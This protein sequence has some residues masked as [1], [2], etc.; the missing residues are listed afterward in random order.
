MRPDALRHLRA[1]ALVVLLAAVISALFLAQVPLE[2]TRAFSFGRIDGRTASNFAGPETAP[3]GESYRWTFGAGELVLASQAPGAHILDIKLSAPRPEPASIPVQV[4][5]NG[6]PLLDVALD[7]TAREYRVVVPAEMLHIGTNHIVLLSPTFQPSAADPR[8]LGIVAFDLSWSAVAPMPWLVPLQ[9]VSVVLVCAAACWLLRAGGAGVAWR[10]VAVVL[11]VAIALAMRHGDTRFIYRWNAIWVCLL[12]A[13]TLAALAFAV[14]RWPNDQP[15]RQPFLV[16]MRQ[17]APAAGLFVVLTLLTFAPLLLNITTSFPGEV[18]DANEYLWKIQWFTD[19]LIHQ[20]RS[21]AFVPHIFYPSGFELALSE[22]TPVT[23]LLG[24]PLTL[25]FGG[26][27]TYNL[28][29]VVSFVLTGFFTYLLAHRLGANR[30]AALVAGVLFGFCFRHFFH[31]T[32]H[33]PLIPMQWMVLAWYGWEGVLVRRR[34]WDGLVAGFGL[35]LTFWA[36]WYYGST[37]VLLLALYTLIRSGRQLPMLWRSWRPAL[38]AGGIVLLLVAPI[39]QPYLELRAAELMDKHSY[40]QM[41]IHAAQPADYLRTNPL[42]PLWGSWAASFYRPV[43]GEYFV[44]VGVVAMVLGTIGVLV[45]RR[46]PLVWALALIAAINVVL[47]FGPELRIGETVYSMPVRFIY[48]HVP[49]LDGI[50]VWSRM[51]IYV[52]LCAALL[53]SV[54]LSSVPV[55][56]R[57]AGWAVGLALAVSETATGITLA[58]AAPRPVDVWLGQQPNDGAVIEMPNGFTGMSEYATLFSKRPTAI[59]YGTFDPRLYLESRSKLATFP[60]EQALD[61]IRRWGVRY[62]VVNVAQ[63]ERTRPDWID[64]LAAEPDIREVYNQYGYSIYEVQP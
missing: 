11:F 63:M 35:A 49:I 37:F 53:A 19:A 51:S 50:R 44:T 27:V 9:I 39:A 41:L 1:D 30:G 34:T 17:H 64:A 62:I 13:A 22:M 2:T 52:T 56:W 43:T 33:L 8:T 16:W 29:I 58:S 60:D 6:A 15:G 46:R 20:H 24:V 48:N 32:G 40:P 21:P 55:R 18:G 59:G 42:H 23:T 45:G 10:V 12:V 25:L 26:L 57:R 14:G 5:V 47:T 3:T 54:A 28:A 7:A 36:S 38:L 4:Q 31:T 61:I